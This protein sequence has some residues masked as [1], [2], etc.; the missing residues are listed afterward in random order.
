MSVVRTT[1]GKHRR[2]SMNPSGT[3]GPRRWRNATPYLWGRL[4]DSSS[5]VRPCRN[6]GGSA[7]RPDA[8]STPG[9]PPPDTPPD[10]IRAGS[11]SRRAAGRGWH[12]SLRRFRRDRRGSSTING[13]LALAVFV[14]GFA[15]LMEIVHTRF[16]ADRMDRAA[17]A[18]ARAVALDRNA[19]RC[20][21]IRHE[22]DLASGFDCDDA[23]TIAVD[24]DVSPTELPATL[25]AQVQAGTGDL[26]FVRIFWTRR[27]W[28][29]LDI[30]PSAN[31][32]E[33]DDDGTASPDPDLLTRVA[34][35]LARC[36]P[37]D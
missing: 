1:R 12:G 24:H 3:Q 37:S 32:A 10:R 5:R 17:R 34:I 19:D 35:G 31:A 7:G 9:T 22:L 20:A 27:L 26:V 28:S 30:V 13:A 11:P 23:W 2:K 21:A 29:F 8:G 18:V 6:E 14:G 25:G 15:G 33:G 36:E 4:R 16:D